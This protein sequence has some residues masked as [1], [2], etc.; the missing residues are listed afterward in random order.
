MLLDL[1]GGNLENLDSSPQLKL[2]KGLLPFE[3]NSFIILTPEPTNFMLH[4]EISE[5]IFHASNKLEP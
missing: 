1:F 4:F 5:T 3:A 2:M